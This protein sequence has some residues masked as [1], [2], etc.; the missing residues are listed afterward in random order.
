VPQDEVNITHQWQQLAAHYNVQ[1]NVCIA[2]ALF[3]GVI[4][5][6]EAQRYQL[7]HYNLADGFNLVG[8]GQLASAT[9]SCDRIIS[10]GNS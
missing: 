6:Q 2:A 7:D 3:Q 8:L 5:Q 9:N 10:F 1:L 4:D